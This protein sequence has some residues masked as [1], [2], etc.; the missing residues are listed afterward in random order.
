MENLIELSSLTFG[1]SKNKPL[2]QNLDLA[3]A[4][5]HIYGMFGKNGTGKTTLLKQ[6]TGLLF[7]DKGESVIFGQQAYQRK[8]A[9]LQDLFLLPENFELPPLSAETFRDVHG[10]LYPRFSNEQFDNFLREFDIPADQQLTKLSFGQQKKALL[11]FAL[12]T[13]TRLLLMDEPTNGLDIPSKSQFRR[14]LAGA[15]SEEQS[16]LIS[17]HQVRDLA[18][19]ID[20]VIILENGQIIF[21]EAIDRIDQTLSFQE[22]KEGENAEALF[23]EPSFSGHKVIVPASDQQTEIDLELLFSGVLTNP[24][25]IQ[26]QFKK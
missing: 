25:I 4:P 8:P 6:M 10:P 20:E 13:N 16:V 7:P 15:I 9:V 17:T 23:S 19:L 2:F 12:A 14:V 26:E 3:L 24:Q 1:Y 5:G 18:S 11:S 22:V 21:Q